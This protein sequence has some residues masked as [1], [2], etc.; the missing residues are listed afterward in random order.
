MQL[1]SIFVFLWLCLVAQAL[2]TP[3]RA[4]VVRLRQELCYAAAPADAPA[5][6]DAVAALPFDCAREPEYRAYRDGWVWLKLRDPSA[7]RAMPGG[8]QL[9][10][11]Q[12]R[13]HRMVALVVARDGSVQSMDLTPDTIGEN[14]ALGGTLRMN[15]KRPGSEVRSVYVGF[16]KL[17][18]LSLMRKLV[19]LSPPAAGTLD[20][21]WLGLMGVF[22]GAIL[23]AL[24]YNLLI[25]TGQ[26]L[27]F[28]RWYLLWSTLALAY[29]FCWT[30]VLAFAIPGFA[31]PYAVGADYILVAALIGS[32][33]VFFLSVMEEGLLPRWLSRCGWSLAALNVLAGLA[34]FANTTLPPAT[35]DRWLNVIFVMSSLYVAT[36]V[37]FAIRAGSRVVWFYLAG[38][39]PVLLVFVLRVGR[40]FGLLL[41]D[42]TVDMGTFA[43]LAFES[44]AL[45]LAI[46][47]RFRRLGKER[48]AAEQARRA[49]A[50]ESETFRRAAHTDFLTGLGNRASF[51]T[52]LRAMCETPGERHFMLLLVDVDNL[53]DINDR[54]GHDGGDALLESVGRGLLEA[55]GPSAQVSRIGGD[56]FAILLPGR[57]PECLKVQA[58]LEALQGTTLTHGGRSWSLSLSIGLAR[59]PEDARTSDVLVKNADLALY[60]AKQQ[61]RRSLH[62]YAPPMRAQLDR[63]RMFSEEAAGGIARGEFSLHY[64]PI[65]DVQTGLPCSH[66]ALLRWH[67]PQHGTMTPAVFSDMLNERT[68]GL[69]VQN[70]VL[71]MALEALQAHPELLPKISVNFTAAQL[72]GPHPAARL[73]ARLRDHGIAPER[74][75]VEVTEEFVLDRTLG[76]T[77][78]ALGLL[79]EAGITVALDDFG[80]GYASLIHLK[81]LPF[82]MLKID[83]SF[84]LGLFEDDGH[85]EEIIRVIVGLGHGLGK[86]VV[87]EGVETEQQR[88]KLA[89]L[90]CEFG[91]GFLFAR[92][93]SLEEMLGSSASHAA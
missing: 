79:H 49:I 78:K 29:G 34:A 12:T 62:L 64:Q 11:D 92:P 66:E 7:L 9:A 2:P 45:S 89:E 50:I 51:Q 93:R 54:L 21:M 41:Q 85:S 36:G 10:A 18:H 15:V 91:Q 56:E 20:R 74:L 75:C 77:A 19:A 72:D 28:Q 4:E 1:K 39:T 27:A 86:Q 65:V 38:W 16:L 71:D 69:A 44:V 43:A 14:W 63:R 3:A 22:A 32:G 60:H 55:A 58:A 81:Q 24:A 52:I 70:H 42:D 88:R 57:E 46:A 5:A 8:W 31:G 48:D 68:T 40:N 67:H 59:F 13:F 84:T 35:V 6:A 73:L 80:T 47:D 33:N 90:G 25:Y 87:A 53:K 23:S 26:R 37:G 61:G 83:R 76:K 30:N 82:D 17:D